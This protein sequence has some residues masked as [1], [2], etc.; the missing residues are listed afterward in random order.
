MATLAVV[1]VLLTASAV[2]RAYGVTVPVDPR[3]A[4]LRTGEPDTP[5]APTILDLAALGFA[6]GAS[7]LVEQR[8]DFAFRSDLPDTATVMLGVFSASST[9]LAKGNL[10]RV[11][12][13]IDAG[14]DAVSGPTFHGNLATDIPEDFRIDPATHITVPAGALFLLV[15]VSDSFYGDNV[16]PDQDLAVS[17]TAV[18]EPSTL[19]LLASGGAMIAWVRRT[20]R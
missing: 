3:A 12:D 6:A 13:A 4:F 11:P 17:V 14:V 15:G 2:T 20:M 1:L 10:N 9:L 7:M 18:P 16:D 5:A 8:G 19:V